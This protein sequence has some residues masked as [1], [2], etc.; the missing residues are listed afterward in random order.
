[1]ANQIRIVPS[2]IFSYHNSI[3]EIRN[4]IKFRSRRGEVPCFLESLI[5]DELEVLAFMASPHQ[6]RWDK[7]LLSSQILSMIPLMI[8]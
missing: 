4:N 6:V 7:H 8:S 3:T 1:M 2:L 5:L